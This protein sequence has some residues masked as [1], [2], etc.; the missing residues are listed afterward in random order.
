MYI[1]S[2]S[3]VISATQVNREQISTS[4]TRWSARFRLD[5]D[6][7]LVFLSEKLRDIEQERGAIALRTVDVKRIF[8]EALRESYDP[9][10][11]V[12]LQGTMAVATGLKVQA[13]SAIASLAG[14]QNT[15]QTVV[16]LVPA[17]DYE[18]AKTRML[19]DSRS[20]AGRNIIGLLARSNPDLDDLANDIY[21]R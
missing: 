7:R 18:A 14:E 21:P 16:E 5:K 4:S 9:L 11:R 13:G 19:D 20:R 6:G 10:P 8:N 17:G 12:S 15:I 2:I 3:E 1:M